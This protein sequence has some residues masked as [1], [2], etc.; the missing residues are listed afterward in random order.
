VD[1]EGGQIGVMSPREALQIAREREL[2]LVEIAPQATPPVCRIIDFGKFRYEQQKRD[3]TQRKSNAQGQLK[4]V[5]LHPRTDT[6]DV[7]FKTRHAREFLAE[8]HKVKFTVV[9][10]GREITRRE[11]GQQLLEQIIQDL[12]DDAKIDQPLRTD[13]HNMS[14][15]M[16]PDAKK[17]K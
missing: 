9:F 17:K 7:D 16:A 6:H 12:A 1:E 11:I 14:V 10:K 8:G 3:K 2:D 13:G 4:E 5:R 15:I